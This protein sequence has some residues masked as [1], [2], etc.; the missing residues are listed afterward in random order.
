VGADVEAGPD[1]GAE[2]LALVDELSLWWMAGCLA[3]ERVPRPVETVHDRL[4][5]HAE[6]LDRYG[7]RQTS[8]RG[9]TV[10]FFVVYTSDRGRVVHAVVQ[11][12]EPSELTRGPGSSA[13]M[14]MARLASGAHW[15][16]DELSPLTALRLA[17]LPLTGVRELSLTEVERFPE[18]S[19][20]ATHR[21]V[22]TDGAAQPLVL[23]DCGNRGAWEPTP[24]VRELLMRSAG[25]VQVASVGSAVRRSI[26]IVLPTG[27]SVSGG[28][29]PWHGGALLVLPDVEQPTVAPALDTAAVLELLTTARRWYRDNSFSHTVS[30]RRGEALVDLVRRLNT[31]PWPRT[32]LTGGVLAE[33]SLPEWQAI[34]EQRETGATDDRDR[35]LQDL[36][37]AQRD[38]DQAAAQRDKLRAT[39]ITRSEDLTAATGHT[40][41]LQRARERLTRLLLS[42]RARAAAADSPDNRTALD[43]A[44]RDA[45]AERDDLA[46]ALAGAD[47][48]LQDARRE[49]D[50]LRRRQN[51]HD[52][53][54]NATTAA[55]AGAEDAEAPEPEFS[56]WSALLDAAQQLP[57]LWISPDIGRRTARL[58]P[59]PDWLRWTWRSMAALSDYAA[60]VL[61]RGQDDEPLLR[62]FASY[63]A[64]ASDRVP[65][66]RLPRQRVVAVESGQVRGSARLAGERMLPVPIEMDPSGQALQAEHIR[67]G[68]SAPWPRLHFCHRDGLVAIGWLGPHLHNTL[69]V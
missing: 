61:E 7:E 22:R 2:P 51:W 65:G 8:S 68:Y 17:E 57:H 9:P 58:D 53:H 39:L 1:A 34:E 26:D 35:M 23:I 15:P 33:L 40:E 41:R 36:A 30:H 62:T 67:I 38:R 44:H 6:V 54:R 47:E 14:V 42:A 66:R 43:A 49:I 21:L 60:A 56:S 27:A 25:M 46:D 3:V 12:T 63:V 64:A 37:A 5:Q 45:V 32:T 16:L 10:G 13:V 18:M 31:G 29:V 48:E 19:L 50:D 11:V 52:T 4:N 24:R 20:S 59:R 55:R 69:K 28:L